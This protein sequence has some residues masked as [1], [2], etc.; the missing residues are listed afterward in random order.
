LFF[1]DTT[2]YDFKGCGGDSVWYGAHLC[3][4]PAFAAL[5][6]RAG[7]RARRESAEFSVETQSAR[8][9]KRVGALPIAGPQGIAAK[10]AA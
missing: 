7:L 9:A 8:G 5:T 10:E 1:R 4:S 6:S 3:N 2:I